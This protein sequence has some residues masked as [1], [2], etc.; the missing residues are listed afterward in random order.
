MYVL[1]LLYFICFRIYAPEPT[2]CDFNPQNPNN[3]TSQAEQNPSQN[4]P[5]LALYTD[6]EC[7]YQ[8]P[9]NHVREC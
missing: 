3:L 8:L 1:G 5:W 2:N 4:H 9:D 7:K 6:G